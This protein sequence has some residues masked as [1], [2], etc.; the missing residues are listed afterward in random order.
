MA[1]QKDSRGLRPH[2]WE[3]PV[4]ACPPNSL[5]ANK[6]QWLDVFLRILLTKPHNKGS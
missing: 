4:A 5:S 2:C 3:L 6:A 1:L